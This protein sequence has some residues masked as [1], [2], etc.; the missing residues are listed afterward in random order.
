MLF[1]IGIKI[2]LNLVVLCI[3]TFS[4]MFCVAPSLGWYS[5]FM[6]LLEESPWYGLL[7]FL[8]MSLPVVFSIVVTGAAT[9][10]FG[11]RS[12]VDCFWRAWKDFTV[13]VE[14]SNVLVEAPFEGV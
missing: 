1:R 5:L 8:L 13:E 3:T 9:V 2:P 7:F 6:T 14:S 12:V 10:Y 4:L 11:Y